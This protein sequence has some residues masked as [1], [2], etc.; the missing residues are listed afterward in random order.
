[1]IKGVLKLEVLN[2]RYIGVLLL[3]R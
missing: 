1:M 3:Y 2:N